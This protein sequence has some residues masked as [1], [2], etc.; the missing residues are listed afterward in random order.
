MKRQT[1]EAREAVQC[2]AVPCRSKQN[3]TSEHSNKGKASVSLNLDW[4]SYTFLVH[5]FCNLF[6]GNLTRLHMF[7]HSFF[8]KTR[9]YQTK[10][11]GQPGK[12][13]ITIAVSRSFS[14]RP[15]Y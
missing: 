8:A 5:I 9:V 3:H 13:L 11:K 15:N 12:K 1:T 10:R 6:F 14:R 4:P 7:E 2:S